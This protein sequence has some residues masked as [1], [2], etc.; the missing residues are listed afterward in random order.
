M[1]SE[2][3]LLLLY[4]SSFVFVFLVSLRDLWFFPVRQFNLFACVFLII[5]TQ[6]HGGTASAFF[7][8]LKQFTVKLAVNQSWTLNNQFHARQP[9][10]N[11]SCLY[12]LSP[13]YTGELAAL[14]LFASS[15][16][17]AVLAPH[18]L[19]CGP[20]SFPESA[21]HGKAPVGP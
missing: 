21:V 9:Q 4:S 8:N 6:T 13:T 20:P 15:R 1:A 12:D 17:P 2:K 16:S 19:T 3:T 14:F 5:Y 18:A 7:V 10:N 11:Y